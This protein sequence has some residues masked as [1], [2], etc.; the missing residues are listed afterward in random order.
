MCG[1]SVAYDPS[2][3]E[4]EM[5]LS[6]KLLQDSII[7]WQLLLQRLSQAPA[8]VLPCGHHCS[9]LTHEQTRRKRSLQVHE[10]ST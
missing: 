4:M 9:I 3:E 8:C 2:T 5:I 7:T 1:R 6:R 10:A